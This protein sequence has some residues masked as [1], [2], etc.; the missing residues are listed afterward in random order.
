MRVMTQVIYYKFIH[1]I[2]RNLVSR[3]YSYKP[4]INSKRF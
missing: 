1:I 4:E 3:P 2:G